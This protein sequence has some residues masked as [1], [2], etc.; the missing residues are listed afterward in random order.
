MRLAADI[1]AEIIVLALL[2]CVAGID[3][4]LPELLRPLLDEPLAEPPFDTL[5]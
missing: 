3:G 4:P 1:I 2:E 5:A